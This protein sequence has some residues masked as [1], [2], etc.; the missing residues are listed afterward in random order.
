[1]NKGFTLLELSIVLVII[2][3]I[4]GG[5]TAGADLIRSAELNSVPN[6]INKYEVALNVF[7]LKYNAIP[8]DMK[9]ATSYWGVDTSGCPNGKGSGTCNGNGD[10]NIDYKNSIADP[11]F[12]DEDTRVWEHLGLSGIVNSEFNGG[13]SAGS[14]KRIFGENM[15]PAKN[16][17]GGYWIL[18]HQQGVYGKPRV[19]SIAYTNQHLSSSSDNGMWQGILTPEDALAIDSKYDDG[20]ADKGKMSIING[21]V[22][23]LT[24][25]NC[26]NTTGWP[27]SSPTEL[28]LN[29]KA[30]N[31]ILWT[32]LN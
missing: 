17:N 3:L 31:C 25:Q 5:V 2:G 20:K 26:V 13:L 12:K 9:N 10:G 19:N 4:V 24:E 28:V 8:G 21:W 18:N 11:N 29:Q 1:M 23:G 15:M 30:T 6:D 32:S 16:G 27:P 14:I 22:N 7:K